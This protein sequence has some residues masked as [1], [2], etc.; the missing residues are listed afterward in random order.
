QLSAQLPEYMIPSHFEVLDAIPLNSNGK[1]D[2]KLLPKP[3]IQ[4]TGHTEKL[5]DGSAE[6]RISKIWCELLEVDHVRINDNFFEIGGHSMLV[7][8]MKERLSK[9]FNKD[10]TPVDI[11]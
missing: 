4:Q 9:E 6:Q 8:P 2:K 1:V 10:V 11:F 5:N 3:A 7:L